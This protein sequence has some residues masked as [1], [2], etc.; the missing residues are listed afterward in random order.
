MCLNERQEFLDLLEISIDQRWK[1]L[2]RGTRDGF[3]TSDFHDKCDEKPRTLTIIKTESG[4]VLGGYTDCTWDKSDRP[5]Y[6]RND[7]VFS[8]R[9]KAHD[10]IKKYI[11]SI[12]LL[13]LEKNG[14]IFCS[15]KCG[16]LFGCYCVNAVIYSDFAIADL[17][18]TNKLNLVSK[19]ESSFGNYIGFPNNDYQSSRV[20]EIEVFQSI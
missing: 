1:L 8:F 18:N 19:K 11:G 6:G 2:Y 9:N 15:S 20:S 12:P 3:R 7:Y 17:S 16:P 10:K 14:T 5:K 4:D 13:L